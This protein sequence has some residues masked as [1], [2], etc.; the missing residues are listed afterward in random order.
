MGATPVVLIL[1]PIICP[2]AMQHGIDPVLLGVIM[3]VNMEIGIVTLPV[4]F[5]LFV[6]S[7]VSDLYGSVSAI[8]AWFFDY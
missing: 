1:A 7:G 8:K 3:V 5:D 6:A 4:G 2:L